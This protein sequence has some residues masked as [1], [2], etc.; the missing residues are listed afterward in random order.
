MEIAVPMMMANAVP[1]AAARTRN[2][3]IVLYDGVELLDF[4]GP[5]EVFAAAG[6]AG[7]SRGLPAF[8]VYTVSRSKA[9]ITSQNFVRVLPEFSIDEVPRP[10]LIVIPGGAA[11][12][13]MDDPKFLAWTTAAAG[14]AEIAM[15]VCTG[16]MALGRAGL[17]DGHAVTISRRIT[18]SSTPAST[19]RAASCNWPA[20]TPLQA[21]SMMR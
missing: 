17:L 9:P 16:A 14:N 7:A 12:S 10:D 20:C 13:L 6:H 18:R 4:A 2:V 3:A 15:T 11:E 5:G 1:A 19:R 21:V 8:R